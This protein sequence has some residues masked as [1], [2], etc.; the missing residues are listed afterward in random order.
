MNSARLTLLALALWAMAPA[1]A[2]GVIEKYGVL[3][4]APTPVNISSAET[5]AKATRIRAMATGSGNTSMWIKP[6]FSV[7]GDGATTNYACIEVDLYTLNQAGTWKHIG[8]A[9]VGT[10]TASHSRTTDSG[11]Y[12]TDQADI[13]V[14]L[15]MATH[16]DIRATS[17]LTGT[18]TLEYRA[19]PI[20]PT[21]GGN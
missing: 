14:D 9:Y 5:K 1:L 13:V 19:G 3:T 15:G 8:T 2:Q 21:P 7:V 11:R 6:S 18:V 20:T 12:T 16:V 10:A 17:L 4:T